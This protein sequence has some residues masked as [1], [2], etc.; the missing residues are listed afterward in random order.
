MSSLHIQIYLFRQCLTRGRTGRAVGG[1]AQSKMA[2]STTF[3][4]WAAVIV[5]IRLVAP[6]SWALLALWSAGVLAPP[7]P[8]VAL[9]A[10]EC[11]FHVWFMWASRQLQRITPLPHRCKTRDQR[12]RLIEQCIDALRDG[13]AAEA[14]DACGAGAGARVEGARAFLEGWFRGS[15]LEDITQQDFM[16]WGAWAFYNREVSRVPDFVKCHVSVYL[17]TSSVKCH[18]RR[19]AFA[20]LHAVAATLTAGPA[21]GLLLRSPTWA[22]RTARSSEACSRGNPMPHWRCPQS[23]VA[24][25]RCTRAW[26]HS[27]VANRWRCRKPWPLAVRHAPKCTDNGVHAASGPSHLAH[28]APPLHSHARRAGVRG[29]ACFKGTRIRSSGSSRPPPARYA[30]RAVQFHPHGGQSDFAW[31]SARTPHGAYVW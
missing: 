12:R 23:L 25:W 24:L 22:T 8:L 18:P 27:R 1:Y 9:A 3:K 6:L 13:E 21:S 17:Y 5:G 15:K 10:A 4:A 28:R 2:R 16:Q 29:G 31:L 19:T 26:S 11:A 14:P 7:A 30:S 20:S